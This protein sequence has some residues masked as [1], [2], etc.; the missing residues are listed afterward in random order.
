MHLT[1]SDLEATVPSIGRRMLGKRGPAGVQGS[2]GSPLAHGNVLSCKVPS[3]PSAT[4]RPEGKEGG[5]RF[6]MPGKDDAVTCSSCPHKFATQKS[7]TA[8]SPLLYLYQK[9]GDK[10]VSHAVLPLHRA[11]SAWTHQQDLPRGVPWPKTVQILQ[12]CVCVCPHVSVQIFLAQAIFPLLSP[13]RS[14]FPPSAEVRKRSR[15]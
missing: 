1:F 12:L 14:G 11:E 9:T 8:L 15:H 5:T 13:T 2:C 3:V 4:D 6:Q 7:A 10:R